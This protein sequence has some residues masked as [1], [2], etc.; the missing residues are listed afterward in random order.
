MT[1]LSPTRVT[2]TGDSQSRS[3]LVPTGGPAEGG[4]RTASG[5][6]PSAAPPA[7]AAGVVETNARTVTDAPP[8]PVTVNEGMVRS[9]A[10]QILAEQGPPAHLTDVDL[11][12][13]DVLADGPL[14]AGDVDR[15]TR[16]AL[17]GTVPGAPDAV[18]DP[19]PPQCAPAARACVDVDGKRAW[20]VDDGVV[21]YGPVPVTTGKPGYETARGTHQI[22]RHVRDDHSR[23]FDTPMPYSTYFTVGGMAFHEGRLD[24]PSHG[25]VHLGRQ[26]AA[27]FFEQLRVGDEIVAF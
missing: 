17:L 23:I 11:I 6:S 2:W 10:H 7:D 18:G 24:E 13:R 5:V 26:A 12:A 20:M 3:D 27:H 19:A 22:L 9:V 16:D 14:D 21:T 8:Q 15:V 4:S 1:G 25:C